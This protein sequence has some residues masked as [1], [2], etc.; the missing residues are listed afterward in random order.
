[1][2][3]NVRYPLDSRARRVI[4]LADLWP[5]LLT[6]DARAFPAVH[7]GTWPPPATASAFAAAAVADKILVCR[8]NNNIHHRLPPNVPSITNKS[9]L[10]QTPWILPH[11]RSSNSPTTFIP[12]LLHVTDW[13]TG[14][15]RTLE[16]Y[17][18]D[19]RSDAHGVRNYFSRTWMCVY[20]GRV[21]RCDVTT[22]TRNLRIGVEEKG[23]GE[24]GIKMS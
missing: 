7:L 6:H 12:N 24:R 19:R 20:K 21:I 5:Y 14:T 8:T 15:N 4:W 16:I 10:P 13:E 23:G 1:M 11:P 18:T 9:P 17:H 22:R 3:L 2:P